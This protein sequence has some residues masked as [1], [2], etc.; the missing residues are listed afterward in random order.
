MDNRTAPPSALPVGDESALLPRLKAGD[1][2][3]FDELVRLA[4]PRMLS[5]ARRLLGSEQ[6]AQDAV[7]DAFL[8]AF[9]SIQRF[10]GRSQLSTW[11]HRIAVNASLMKLRS[12]RRRPERSIEDLLPQFGADGHYKNPPPRW[13]PAAISGIEQSEVRSLIRSKIEE[14][15]EPYREV[16]MIRDIEQIDTDGAA[17]ILGISIPAVKTRLHRARQALYTLLNPYFTEAQA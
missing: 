3:A 6:D 13:Q 5:V 7:Q 11:L 9:K 17:A 15:P 10:D 12:A 4:G 1:D 8:S 16:L 2:A 14:L